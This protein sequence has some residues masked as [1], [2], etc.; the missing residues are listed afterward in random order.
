MSN[1]IP[2]DFKRQAPSQSPARISTPYEEFGIA[3]RVMF[4]AYLEW[5]RTT[6]PTDAVRAEIA[7]TVSVL[8]QMHLMGVRDAR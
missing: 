6:P 3:R 8:D 2:I 7:G 1:I 5:L 4:Q